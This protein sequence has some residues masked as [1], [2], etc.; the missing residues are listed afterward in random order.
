ME[1]DKSKAMMVNVKTP[2]ADTEDAS[3]PEVKADS[4]VIVLMSCGRPMDR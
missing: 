3:S 1:S 2:A 4:K